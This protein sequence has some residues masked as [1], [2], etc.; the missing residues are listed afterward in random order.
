MKGD[1]PIHRKHAK[2]MTDDEH[3][4]FIEGIRERR[5]KPIQAFEEATLLKAEARKQQLEEQLE[6]QLGMFEKEM[7]RADKV[8]DVLE[9][10]AIKLRAIK[11]ELEL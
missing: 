6:K 9:K 5:L 7:V 2:D 1:T 8:M 4:A 3:E 10:R 11:L